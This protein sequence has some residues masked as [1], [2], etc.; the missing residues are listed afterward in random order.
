MAAGV[1]LS[2]VSLRPDRRHGAIGRPDSPSSS[3]SDITPH[4]CL[5]MHGRASLD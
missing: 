3:L 2:G 5:S 4:E 1:E